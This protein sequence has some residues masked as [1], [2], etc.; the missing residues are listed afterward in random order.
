MLVA[1]TGCDLGDDE[2]PTAAPKVETT[3]TVAGDG[4][5]VARHR[6]GILRVLAADAACVASSCSAPTGLEDRADAL[7]AEVVPLDEAL[8]A[9]PADA[10]RPERVATSA[11]R[12][13][14]QEMRTCFELS[15]A[16]H[17]GS[18]A[19]ADCRRPVA[20]FHR[21]VEYLRAV[22]QAASASAPAPAK[23]EVAVFVTYRI[24]SVPPAPSGLY[25][26]TGTFTTTG[27]VTDSGKA[28]L[29]FRI[30]ARGPDTIRGE[31][32]LRSEQ[33]MLVVRFQASAVP[34]GSRK[35]NERPGPMRIF[36]MGVS[37]IDTGR[38]AYAQLGGRTG[39][40]GYTIDFGARTTSSLYAFR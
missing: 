27:A 39:T 7:A 16:K 8:S 18:P 1:L 30:T 34:V 38:R 32:T 33:G 37:R 25:R 15:A 2:G 5:V 36:G 29:V 35:L 10:K 4:D 22:I 3:T 40:M 11:L 19:L 24:T 13:A 20:E 9:R 14:V 28:S 12:H 31:E 6:A 21:A 26:A 23:P 17:D